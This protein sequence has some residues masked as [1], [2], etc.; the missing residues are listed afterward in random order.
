MKECRP[1]CY[2]IHKSPTAQVVF[3]PPLGLI[4]GDS[5]LRTVPHAFRWLVPCLYIVSSP[6]EE[7]RSGEP[8]Q[9]SWASGHFCNS[10]INLAMIKIFHRKPAPKKYGYSNGLML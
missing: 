6:H 1:T 10:V 7:K 5:E 2:V 8:S 4:R 9:I 3:W